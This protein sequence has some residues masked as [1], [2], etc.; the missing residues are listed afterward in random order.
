MEML[1]LLG[2]LTVLIRVQLFLLDFLMALLIGFLGLLGC[3]M[4]HQMELWY[5]LEYQMVLKRGVWRLW[6]SVGLSDGP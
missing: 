4:A 5:Q 6:D 3:Q 2:F 1:C